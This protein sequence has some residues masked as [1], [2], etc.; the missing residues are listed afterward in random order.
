[1]ELFDQG[2]AGVNEARLSVAKYEES[3]PLY[4]LIVYRRRKVLI[5]YVP[6]G[7]SRVLLGRA[8]QVCAAFH[9]LWY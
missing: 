9:M 7:T 3:S 1:M 8:I 5:K 4:G 6:E 2:K